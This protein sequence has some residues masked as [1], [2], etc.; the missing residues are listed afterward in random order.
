[1][2]DISDQ[3]RG[4]LER[5]ARDLERV[6]A[7]RLESLV[8]YPGHQGDETLHTVAIV[9]GLAFGDLPRCLPF[10][11]G[12]RRARI[13]VPLMLS[14]DE[15]R[16]TIDIFPLEYASIAAGAV[17]IRGPN[18]FASVQVPIDDVRR[19]CET[20]AKSHLIHLR[21]GFL[22]SRGASSAIA[23]LIA[24]SAPPFRTLLTNIL[25]LPR[26]GA[27][28]SAA[29]LSDESLAAGAEERIGIPSTLVREV[30]GAQS[31]IA[32][33][34]ALLARYV[35]AAQRIWDYVDGWAAAN[36]K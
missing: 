23:S 1:M 22:E 19:A 6:F 10:V 30:L 25:R 2:A 36:A 20:Q 18:P 26:D 8:H 11:D 12:W 4:A 13:A 16:R 28:L 24:S 29:H 27:Q 15:L 32:D 33:P 3:Q 17:A 9:N 34:S 5:L 35:D 21:E 14:R 7:G 31:T